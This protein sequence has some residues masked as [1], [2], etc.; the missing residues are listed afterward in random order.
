MSRTCPGEPF[1]VPIDLALGRDK[2]ILEEAGGG[3]LRV[4]FENNIRD[5]MICLMFEHRTRLSLAHESHSCWIGSAPE[6]SPT[7]WS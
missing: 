5:A 2:R 3:S 4:H 1:R 7:Y 6:P